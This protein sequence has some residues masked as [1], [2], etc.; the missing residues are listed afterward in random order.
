MGLSEDD[1]FNRHDEAGGY[2]IIDG[3]DVVVDGVTLFQGL[4]C[5]EEKVAALVL[6]HSIMNR[7][8]KRSM[9]ALLFY[10]QRYVLGID[11]GAKA[12]QRCLRF[13]RQL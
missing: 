2:A 11:D 5:E 3:E 12:P 9:A 8:F 6:T 7:K 10:V 1:L 13:V 4:K